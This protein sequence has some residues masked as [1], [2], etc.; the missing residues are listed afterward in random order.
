MNDF[1]LVK[2]FEGMVGKDLKLLRR[3]RFWEFWFFCKDIGVY[4]CEIFLF[5]LKGVF[6]L[7]ESDLNFGF[8]GNNLYFLLIKLIFEV[9]FK[10]WDYYIIFSMDVG[11]VLFFF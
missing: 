3:L 4:V 10:I 8:S 6:I 7:N 5:F 1:L 2:I 11:V 9:Y